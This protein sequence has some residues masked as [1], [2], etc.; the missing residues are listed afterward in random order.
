MLGEPFSLVKWYLDCVTEAGDLAIIYCTELRWHGVHLHLNSVLSERDGQFIT[1]TSISHYQLN[2][3]EGKISADLPTFGV[4][5]TWQSD[6]SPYER[7]V[8]EQEA[9]S[10]RWNCLQPRSIVTLR[11]GERQLRGL[12][13]AECLTLTILPWNLPLKQ[14]L[15]GRFVSPQDSLVWVD[16]RG[17]YDTSFG[18]RNGEECSLLTVSEVEVAIPDA[19][20]RIE[21]GVPLR[22]GRLGSTILPDAPML[23]K[24]F[25][26]SVFNVEERKW[27]SRGRLSTGDRSSEGWVIHEVVRW[28]S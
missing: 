9:G 7:P 8:Y 3:A 24:L 17:S 25:P 19:T 15:W 14:L 16:W 4:T 27:R 20:L 18:I 23:G 2:S 10:I 28:E 22:S 26:R 11:I 6:C 1:R 5:G 21:S 12:G 13:Y